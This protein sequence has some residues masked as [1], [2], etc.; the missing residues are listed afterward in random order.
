[1]HGFGGSQYKRRG[2]KSADLVVVKA[3]I[4]TTSDKVPNAKAIAL[5]RWIDTVVVAY[6]HIVKTT[7]KGRRL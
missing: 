7:G 3:D 1:V 4:E 5:E 6:D 2:C